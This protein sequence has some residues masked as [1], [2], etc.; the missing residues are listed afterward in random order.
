[1][2]A[3]KKNTAAN[4]PHSAAHTAASPPPAPTAGPRPTTPQWP[5]G[6]R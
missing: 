2:A 1:M 6:P 4:G 3:R 5:S